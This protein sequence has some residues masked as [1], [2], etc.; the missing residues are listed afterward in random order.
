MLEERHWLTA[1]AVIYVEADA[2]T[3]LPP[4]P[5]TWSVTKAKQ[6]GAVGYHL[7]TKG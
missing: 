4:L 2:R 6:A 1:D 3:G 7:L 5:P